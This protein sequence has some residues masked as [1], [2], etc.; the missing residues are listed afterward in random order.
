MEPSLFL[1]GT[2][3][4]KIALIAFQFSN[5]VGLSLD[6]Q[7]S[8]VMQRQFINIAFLVGS[9]FK[10]ATEGLCGFMDGNVSNDLVGSDGVLYPTGRVLQFAK[11]CTFSKFLIS[12]INLCF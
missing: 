4:E 8:P 5:G 1:N 2:S 10:R 3:K 12:F 6:V 9:S 11:S 7:Y